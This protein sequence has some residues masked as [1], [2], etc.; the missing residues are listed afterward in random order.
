M[1]ARSRLLNGHRTSYVFHFSDTLKTN[2]AVEIKGS[3]D[4]AAKI[5]ASDKPKVVFHNQ[6]IALP[7]KRNGTKLVYFETRCMEP[8][9]SMIALFSINENMSSICGV[10]IYELVTLVESKQIAAAGVG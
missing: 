1:L 4:E 9:A 7:I 5:D 3:R 2:R 8:F 6:N 10:N